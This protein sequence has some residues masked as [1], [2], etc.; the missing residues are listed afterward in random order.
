MQVVPFNCYSENCYVQDFYVNKHHFCNYTAMRV[1][2]EVSQ[3]LLS[4]LIFILNIV[5][6]ARMYLIK[7]ID[8]TEMSALTAFQVWFREKSWEQT[9]ESHTKV[10]LAMI[11]CFFFFFL[12]ES[13]QSFSSPRLLLL[14]LL[15]QRLQH[16][17]YPRLNIIT[18][19]H[20]HT[21][22]KHALPHAS[23]GL[24]SI[25]SS[26]ETTLIVFPLLFFLSGFERLPSQGLLVTSDVV[27]L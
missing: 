27:F 11:C 25:Q 15:L 4:R 2:V 20:T 5:L 21:H 19:I 3:L 16:M 24:V 10:I 12:W 6:I 23:R 18:L 26:G 1:S 13:H 14:L 7:A 8:S 17:V 22:T 9:V